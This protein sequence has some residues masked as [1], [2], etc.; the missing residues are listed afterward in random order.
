MGV[1]KHGC[2]IC[3]VYNVERLSPR[4]HAAV[5][6]VE[7]DLTPVCDRAQHTLQGGGGLVYGWVLGRYLH[8]SIVFSWDCG[9][10]GGGEEARATKYCQVGQNRHARVGIKQTWECEH[11]RVLVRALCPND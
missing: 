10:G 8:Y 2:C 5:D 3:S 4:V 7:M 1:Y 6:P 11:I 9:G